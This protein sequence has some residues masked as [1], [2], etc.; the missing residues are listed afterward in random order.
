[1]YQKVTHKNAQF[2]FN[3]PMN[4]KTRFNLLDMHSVPVYIDN[5]VTNNITFI[6]I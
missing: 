1:M 3:N 6:F 5:D 2:L 4:M